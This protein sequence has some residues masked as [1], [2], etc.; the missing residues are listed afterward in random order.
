MKD[1]IIYKCAFTSSLRAWALK[2]TPYDKIFSYHNSEDAEEKVQE[3]ISEETQ[4]VE[5]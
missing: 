3:L 2:L 4:V 1:Y 5:Y